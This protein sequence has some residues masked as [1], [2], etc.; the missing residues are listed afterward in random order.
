MAL[1]NKIIKGI[2]DRFQRAEGD[3]GSPEVQVAVLTKKIATLSDHLQQHK[4]D[5]HSRRGLI[6]MISQRRRL[7][8]YLKRLKPEAYALLLQELGIRH[9]SSI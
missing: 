3:T 6:A 2:V 7:L 8:T 4:K 9:S 1:S 5:F